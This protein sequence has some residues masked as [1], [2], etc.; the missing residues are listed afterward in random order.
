MYFNEKEDTNIDWE[1]KKN[2]KKKDKKQ[3]AKKIFKILGIIILLIVIALI[4]ILLLKNVKHDNLILNGD[5]NMTSIKVQFI[6]NQDMKLAI[7][8]V[9]V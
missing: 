7:T 4:I 3:V 8:K 2:K 6:M 5:A 9:I 1:L